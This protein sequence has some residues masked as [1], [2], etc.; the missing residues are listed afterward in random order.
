MIAGMNSRPDSAVP[1][2]YAANLGKSVT[3]SA[4]LGFGL[5]GLLLLLAGGLLLAFGAGLLSVLWPMIKGLLLVF[6]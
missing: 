4:L 1:D 3:V 2:A 6:A 5:Y